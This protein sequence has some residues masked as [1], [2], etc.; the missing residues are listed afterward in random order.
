MH[1]P[2]K[3]GSIPSIKKQSFTHVQVALRRDIGYSNVGHKVQSL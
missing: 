2:N 1:L 3:G